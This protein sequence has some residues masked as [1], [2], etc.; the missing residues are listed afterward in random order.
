M[1][2]LSECSRL[3]NNGWS[4]LQRFPPDGIV[5]RCFERACN[6][7][8]RTRI[9]SR[10][11][12]ALS[13][14]ASSTSPTPASQTV[15]FSSK[16][17]VPRAW[18][19]SGDSAWMTISPAS[20][21]IARE[22]DQIVVQ[23]N[24]AGMVAGTYNGTIRIAID[25]KKNTNCSRAGQACGHRRNCRCHAEHVAQSDESELFRRG[26][27][28]AAARETDHAIES[29]RRDVDVDDD[30]AGRVACP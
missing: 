5:P 9:P 13:Y 20:G 12:T 23:V 25:D 24:A 8:G 15:T 6:D 7:I 4:C 3:Q 26:G 29:D 2:T 19:A 10:P 21:T 30:R 17:L 18:N 28:S 11:E 27:R 16:S 14:A 1:T 22:Q